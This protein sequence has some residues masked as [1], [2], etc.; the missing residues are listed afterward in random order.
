[1][2]SSTGSV[3][4]YIIEFTSAGFVLSDTELSFDREEMLY[5]R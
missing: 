5:F 1:M 4:N 3:I 2:R